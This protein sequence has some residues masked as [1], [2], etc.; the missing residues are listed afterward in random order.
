MQVILLQRIESLGQMGEVVNVKPGFAR[1]YLLPQKKA[2]RATDDNRRQFEDRRAQLEA[3]NL[4][5][6]SEA[7]SVAGKMDDVSVFLMRQAGD[8]GQL[9]GSVSARDIATAVTEAGYTVGRNQVQLDRPIKAIGLHTVRVDLHPEVTVSVTVN[10]ARSEEE[11]AV[12]VKTGRAVVGADEEEFEDEI[13]MAVT[14]AEEVFE[15]PTEEIIEE[16]AASTSDEEDADAGN[17]VI[18]GD[19]AAADEPEA[20]AE[21]DA[22]DDG[23]EEKP[24]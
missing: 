3:D 1:N 24:A 20:A 10:V 11:A 22:D 7:E 21:G 16:L 13:A 8:A 9:Y 2:L 6:R 19:E 5:R 17:T 14:N 12:Q 18:T 4:E 23:T 15:A